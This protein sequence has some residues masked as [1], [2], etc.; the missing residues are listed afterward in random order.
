MRRAPIPIPPNG[1][2]FP[3]NYPNKNKPSNELC[4]HLN[5]KAKQ[6]EKRSKPYNFC[7][8]SKLAIYITQ[9]AHKTFSAKTQENRRFEFSHAPLIFPG[10]RELGFF[11]RCAGPGERW[12][13]A[14]QCGAAGGARGG[15]SAP[16][17]GGG[18]REAAKALPS[19]GRPIHYGQHRAEETRSRFNPVP[20]SHNK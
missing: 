16:A 19:V 15:G 17:I 5:P 2:R 12:R 10:P 1:Q 8:F 14:G 4:N 18:R 11:A 20:F 3:L 13:G 6:L 9:L 7:T